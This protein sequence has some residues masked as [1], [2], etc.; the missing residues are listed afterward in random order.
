MATFILVFN[1]L[2]DVTRCLTFPI[3]YPDKE[4]FFSDIEMRYHLWSKGEHTITIGNFSIPKGYFQKIEIYEIDGIYY[5]RYIFGI[6]SKLQ[7]YT[8]EEWVENTK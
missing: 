2:D 6:S 7:I 1:P 8:F 4:A 5:E 3:D